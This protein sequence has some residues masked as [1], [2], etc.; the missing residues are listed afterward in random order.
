MKKTILN[1]LLIAIFAIVAVSCNPDNDE[2]GNENVQL[3]KTITLIDD[4]NG[5][6]DWNFEYDNKNRITSALG[7]GY[8]AIVYNG[9]NLVKLIYDDNILFFEKEGNNIIATNEDGVVCYVINLNSDGYPIR[10]NLNGDGYVS[11]QYLDGNLESIGNNGEIW[12]TF[13]YDNKKSPF[14]HCKTP[15][16]FQICFLTWPMI[17]AGFAYGLVIKNNVTEFYD[18]DGIHSKIECTYEY[19]DNDFPTKM[20]W[21]SKLIATFMF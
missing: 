17:G 15:K 5:N 13:K 2:N 6:S 14:Y 21:N 9:D 3:V 19:N 4:V 8:L 18:D 12:N 16:W 1:Y 11:Y 10:F 7:L 20:Y